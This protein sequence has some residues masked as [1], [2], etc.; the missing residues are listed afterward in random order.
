[1]APNIVIV[2]R[3]LWPQNIRSSKGSKASKAETDIEVS[4]KNGL[5][6]RQMFSPSSPF[7]QKW[8]IFFSYSK[9]CEDAF[10]F[11]F[12]V[13]SL[14][15]RFL[16]SGTPFHAQVIQRPF[17]KENWS[18]KR[19]IIVKLCLACQQPSQ[20][21]A[22]CNTH[23]IFKPI[24]KNLEISLPKAMMASLVFINFAGMIRF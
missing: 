24:Q 21:Q 19:A 22:L 3:G 14:L 6:Q 1:M 13:P 2:K 8:H 7:V 11:C 9:G 17:W 15:F 16:R 18:Q 23:T 12:N 5:C 4:I 10:H 20:E